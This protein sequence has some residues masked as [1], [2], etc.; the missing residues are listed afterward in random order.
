MLDV[1]PDGSFEASSS[2]VRKLSAIDKASFRTHAWCFKCNDYCDLFSEEMEC[3][4]DMSG[5]PCPDMSSA[6][7]GRLEEGKTAPVFIAHAKYHIQKQTKMLIVENV[8]DL[9]LSNK[10]KHTCKDTVLCN[11]N[12]T[13]QRLHK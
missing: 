12:T 2:F 6:G 4:Y 5:L 8:T 1:I 3:D 10:L 7:A 13:E 11:Y 9:G